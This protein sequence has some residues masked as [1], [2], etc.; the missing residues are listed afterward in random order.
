MRRA[1]LQ[2]AGPH[3]KV[4]QDNITFYLA[5]LD[6]LDRCWSDAQSGLEASL[7]Q[8]AHAGEAF[9]VFAC[10]MYLAYV[11]LFTGQQKA[12]QQEL[13]AGLGWA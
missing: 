10:H 12:F 6:M 7:A 8:F 3:Y 11:H 9:K 5:A 4:V 13:E 2:I 1:L